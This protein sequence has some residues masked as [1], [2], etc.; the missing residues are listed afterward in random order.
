MNKIS[1]LVRDV[2]L[3]NLLIFCFGIELILFLGLGVFSI[4]N[5]QTMANNTRVLYD[6]PHTNLV[7]FWEVKS[8]IAQTGDGMRDWI[9][10]GEPMSE[11]Q[12]ANLNEALE[13]LNEIESNKVDKGSKTSDTF[14]DI[15]D[16]VDAWEKKGNE[17][18]TALES[19]Q[20]V[21]KVKAEE[22]RELEQSSI[23]KIDAVITAA[24]KNAHSFRDGAIKRSQVAM[25]V[26]VVFFAI[27]LLL[28]VL[29][30]VMLLQ[31]IMKPLKSL[32]DAA[33]S[34]ETGNLDKEIE[35][36]AKN[37]FGTLANCFRQMQCYLKEVIY[38]VTNN[39]NRMENG[40]F[41]IQTDVDYLGAFES[42][43]RSIQAI[44]DRLGDTLLK[45]NQSAEQV[46]NSS[47]HVSSGAQQLSQGTVEQ[48]SSIEQLAAAIGEVTSQI[49]QNSENSDA[50][51]NQA[52]ET[53][54]ELE[55]GKNNMNSMLRAMN[56]INNSSGEIGKIIKTIEDIAFQTNI[57]ALNAAVEA[58]RAGEA[59]KGF[60]VVADE[61]RNLAGKSSEASQN[62]TELIE[63][64]LKSVKEGTDIANETARS[65]NLIAESSE[66]SA[67]LL[68]K[69]SEASQNQAIS[70]NQISSGIDQISSVV[71][72]SAATAEESAASSEE[73]S[74]QAQILKE[75]VSDFQFNH[76]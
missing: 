15:L 73:L 65:L 16:T 19:G 63:N 28:T 29:F 13:K 56:E 61:V 22:Y 3:R 71:Q 69:I 26:T 45:I 48:A 32:L 35:F 50:A 40:D 6:M 1:K 31:I 66:K 75:L 53:S 60:A 20:K 44:S 52:Q 2:K 11:I 72:S 74:S 37:E 64:S 21:S 47:S 12:R 49:Q 9:L 57:L 42:I 25:L 62:T 14:L 34:I 39:L 46:N 67:D 23:A 59:G 7:G 55:V 41:R 54:K 33:R 18:V 76:E 38:D 5:I 24:S 27:A 43:H 36:D 58:A 51:S 30:L 4:S 68:M 70:V 8:K 10:Y 17:L